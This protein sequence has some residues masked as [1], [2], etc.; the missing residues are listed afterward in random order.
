MATS[1]SQ[2][3]GAALFASGKKVSTPSPNK[4]SSG[5]SKASPGSSITQQITS[6]NNLTLTKSGTS[7][8]S[9]QSSQSSG[10]GDYDRSYSS[11]P[12][13]VNAPSKVPTSVPKS[14]SVPVA[15]KPVTV[16]VV[17]S[18]GSDSSKASTEKSITE[19]IAARNK[20][21]LTDS[22]AKQVM[23]QAPVGS[24]RIETDSEG[25]RTVRYKLSE[26]TY[27]E[28]IYSP[29]GHLIS[30]GSKSLASIA[31]AGVV[32]GES[33][34]KVMAAPG[35]EKGAQTQESSS[36]R[37]SEGRPTATKD[38]ESE[39]G[40]FGDW[41]LPT[42]SELLA[43]V[44]ESDAYKTY[45]LPTVEKLTGGVEYSKTMPAS[46]GQSLDVVQP[47]VVK[48]Q[49]D[50]TPTPAVLNTDVIKPEEQ[51]PE[52]S[53]ELSAQIFAAQGN[54]DL[55]LG[56][57][58][59]NIYPVTDEEKAQAA[60]EYLNSHYPSGAGTGGD[61]EKI[62]KYFWYLVPGM[63]QASV[64]Y[65]TL[66]SMIND[67]EGII[68]NEFGTLSKYSSSIGSVSPIGGSVV[69][70]ASLTQSQQ[71]EIIR[72]FNEKMIDND[73][74]PVVMALFNA[75]LAEACGSGGKAAD[76][77]NWMSSGGLQEALEGDVLWYS[78]SGAKDWLTSQQGMAAV[79][80]GF[81]LLGA[82]G[83]FMVGGPVASIAVMGTAP[84]STTELWQSFGEAAFKTKGE[85][86]ISGEYS[87]DHV[88]SYQTLYSTAQSSVSNVG[89]AKSLSDGN[90]NLQN[91]KVAREAVQQAEE[92]LRNNWAYL[93]ASRVYDDK[94]RQIDTL[95]NTLATNEA[96]FDAQGNYI[97]KQNPPVGISIINS[98][99]D[100]IVEYAGI[101]G[102]FDGQGKLGE[103][104]ENFVGDVVVKDRSGNELGRQQVKAQLFSGDVTIDAA[105]IVNATQKYSKKAAEVKS[106]VYTV[107]VPLGATLAYAGKSYEGGKSYDIPVSEGMSN[108]AIISQ[109]GRKDEEKVLY[110]VDQAWVG[111]KPVLQA[112]P[113]YS[114]PGSKTY[115]QIDLQTSPDATVTINGKQFTPSGDKTVVPVVSGYYS[116][117][118]SRPGYEDWEKTVY[119]GDGQTLAVSDPSQT[120]KEE[121]EYQ[122]Y[123]SGGSGG[124]GGSSGGSSTVSYGL[125]K[126]GNACTG[127][128][129][130]QDEVRV[131]PVIEQDYS[132]D[133]G[134]HAIKISKTGKKTWLKTVYVSAGDTITVSPAFEDDTGST[135]TG[136]GTGT[137]TTTATE[138]TQRVYINTEPTQAKVLIDGGATGEWTPCYL[139]LHNG[140]YIISTVKS[141]Y[142]QQDTPLYVGSTILWGDAARNR[143]KEERLI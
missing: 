42:A 102:S 16:P 19:Q 48:P 122:D 142:V 51:A 53:T 21:T 85:L 101:K 108:N 141:G 27:I 105:S 98:N 110:P 41:Q 109:P 10:S 82:A 88:T 80:V 2:S 76:A 130:W 75:G 103:L 14:S 86:Q 143:A 137:G 17:K 119:V 3:K 126:Y 33:R 49:A 74:P 121:D 50:L 46:E 73:M 32:P 134:Y 95:K 90:V 133:P 77:R 65:H 116:V 84:F 56:V 128:E 58:G 139:D 129:I 136:T 8:V 12:L 20:L 83:A 28:Q 34:L 37:E 138:T 4:V 22:G 68:T 106:T 87:Q 47:S 111:W 43:P 91:I 94:V 69:T 118:V 24:Q 62:C 52:M 120:I 78:Y 45:I 60:L 93:E 40:L 59:G 55:L 7:L 81:N 92:S 117:K 96:M 13:V 61:N 100:W 26:E 64:D 71:Q 114:A 125:I 135:S 1:G 30:S 25:N 123:S 140:Y 6:R 79:G 54:T 57:E 29:T 113:Y 124:G 127:A 31:P 132:I 115:G 9:K 70:F 89:M 18:I 104:K 35:S 36:A 39:G 38:K 112:D 63:S 23:K 66:V 44:T 11:V 99:E 72:E 15:T 107:T 5:S 131:Y 97:A 67:Y